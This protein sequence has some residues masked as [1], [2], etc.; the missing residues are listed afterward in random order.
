M[1]RLVQPTVL[2]AAPKD[3]GHFEAAGEQSEALGKGED[4]RLTLEKQGDGYIDRVA[5]YIPGEVMAAYLVLDSASLYSA[6]Q[7][8]AKAAAA[9]NFLQVF[10]HHMPLI[11]FLIGLSFTPLY[12]CAAGRQQQAPWRIHALVSTVA[13]FVWAYAMKGNFFHLPAAYPLLGQ[14]PLYNPQFSMYALVVFTLLSG[15]VIPKRIVL[16][17]APRPQSS[18]GG[19]SATPA[20]PAALQPESLETAPDND[21]IVHTHD[22]VD[23][24]PEIPYSTGVARGDSELEANTPGKVALWY[25]AAD[26]RF[27]MR[28][29][30]PFASGYPVGV[31]IHSTEGRSTK[32]DAN[33]EDTIN[34][35]IGKN[36]CYIC[37]SSTGKV[38]QTAPLDH[39]GSHAGETYYPGLGLRLNNKLIG[40]E[41]CCAG[42]VHKVGDSYKPDWNERFT[43]DE[44]RYSRKTA[45]VTEAGYYHQFNAKQEEALLNLLMWLKHNNP[46]VFRFDYVLGHDEIATLSGPGTAGEKTLG[47]KQD[48]GASLSMTMPDYRQMLFAR[49]A[50]QAAQAPSSPGGFE[51][52]PSASSKPYRLPAYAEKLLG[53]DNGLPWHA[54]TPRPEFNFYSGLVANSLHQLGPK[55]VY[56]ESKFDVDND[57]SGGND[58][59][60]VHHKPD[61][62]LHDSADAP[63]DANAYPFVVLPRRGK[64]P[65]HW[66]RIGVGVGDLVICFYKNGASCAAII[67][68]MG[69]DF[70]IGEGSVK[71]ARALGIDPDP[72]NGGLQRVPPGVA[73]VVFPGSRRL[74]PL[75][76]PHEL[77]RT[78]DTP[79]SIEARAWELF[80][81][82]KQHV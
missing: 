1:G 14:G 19:M 82:L 22:E 79:Q 63:L 71:A 72:T 59:G 15:L 45:N 76:R 13:F 38:Y 61:T 73:H 68:D 33:A 81:A 3:D 9:N 80:A 11:A 20:A 37:I 16:A 49:Y 21:H 7:A 27:S 56:Y 50:E 69:P 55:A 28:T 25:P 32:G 4:A 17:Q 58:A 31:V 44:V 53:A 35:G 67:G 78:Q 24:E 60:D 62:S 46:D 52:T 26:R 8:E 70:K 54:A 77:P 36:Y 39:W 43:Q 40:I 74:M 48:P 34:D 41:V 6:A 65:Y 51:A 12:I 75:R 2:R 57:G 18:D 29:K 23:T 64:L 66:G 42:I 47:R 5:K 10:S 30:A